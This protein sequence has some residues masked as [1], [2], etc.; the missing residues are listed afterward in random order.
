MANEHAS[1]SGNGLPIPYLTAVW[2]GM[3]QEDIAAGVRA[4]R[5]FAAPEGYADLK[6]D[7]REPRCERSLPPCGP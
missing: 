6:R 5:I 2:A 7:G 4:G 1:N 3:S